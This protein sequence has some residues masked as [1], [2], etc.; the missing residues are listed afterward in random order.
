MTIEIYKFQGVM[1]MV[2]IKLS[3][4]FVESP[5][6]LTFSFYELLFCSYFQDNFKINFSNNEIESVT[7]ESLLKPELDYN[8]K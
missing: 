1:V 8:F 3:I 2:I 5:L 4:I 7:V 6:N